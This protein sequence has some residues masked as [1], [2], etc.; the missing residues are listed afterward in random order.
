MEEARGLR[1]PY[2]WLELS[3][4]EMRCLKQMCQAS[5]PEVSKAPGIGCI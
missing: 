4:L 1:L 2:V 3:V 5:L